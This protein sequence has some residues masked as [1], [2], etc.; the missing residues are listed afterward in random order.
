MRYI[1]VL[2]STLI[3][4]LPSFAYTAGDNT[5]VNKRDRASGA[6]TADQQSNSSSDMKITQ[7]IRRDVMN[8]DNFSTYAKNIKIITVDGKVTLKGPV[9]SAQEQTTIM[10]YANQAAGATNV[11]NETSVVTD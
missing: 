6:V 2:F 3:L 8:D 9:R 4:S 7:R 10:R 5:K 11:T 1:I